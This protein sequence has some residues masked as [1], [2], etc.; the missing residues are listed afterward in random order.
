ME[1]GLYSSR[2][3]RERLGPFLYWKDMSICDPPCVQEH[4]RGFV[5]ICI[6]D[7]IYNLILMTTNLNLKLQNNKLVLILADNRIEM[8]RQPNQQ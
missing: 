2:M 8:T 1:L 6:Y 4:P 5:T 7:V 3:Q